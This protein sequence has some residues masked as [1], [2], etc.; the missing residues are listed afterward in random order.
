MSGH[1]A[2]TCGRKLGDYSSLRVWHRNCNYSYFEKPQGA[3]HYS[4]YS[5]VFCINCNGMW[6]TKAEYVYSLKDGVPG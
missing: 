1:T 6:R 5:L 4:D 2:C 3:K